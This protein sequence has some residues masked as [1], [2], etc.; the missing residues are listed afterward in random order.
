ME[1]VAALAILGIVVAIAAPFV[2]EIVRNNRLNSTVKTVVNYLEHARSHTLIDKANIIVCAHN[3]QNPDEC[4]D[5]E[6]W[7]AGF[8]LIKAQLKLVYRMHKPYEPSHPGFAPTKPTKPNIEAEAYANNTFKPIPM[9]QGHRFY[10]IYHMDNSNNGYLRSMADCVVPKIDQALREQKITKLNDLTHA[11]AGGLPLAKTSG[12]VD[13]SG[14]GNEEVRLPRSGT[15]DDKS[16]IQTMRIIDDIYT[17]FSADMFKQLGL[18][19]NK[20]D[21][22]KAIYK[23]RAQLDAALKK[24]FSSYIKDKNKLKANKVIYDD[25]MNKCSHRDS[26]QVARDADNFYRYLEMDWYRRPSEYKHLTH[27]EYR[28]PSE[29]KKS[30]TFYPSIYEYKRLYFNRAIDRYVARYY[31]DKNGN[32]SV[33]D[34]NNV[35]RELR[36]YGAKKGEEIDDY[37]STLNVDEFQEYGELKKH[38]YKQTH[39]A[40]QYEKDLA[41]YEIDKAN[42]EL[43]LVRY[44]EDYKQYL[45]RLKEYNNRKEPGLYFENPKAVLVINKLPSDVNVTLN[46][47]QKRIIY[48]PNMNIIEYNPY[49]WMMDQF[50]PMYNVNFVEINISDKRDKQ[51]SKNICI[52]NSGKIK[53]INGTEKCE[54]F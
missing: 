31:K 3:P 51:F 15:I 36:K 49:Y 2:Y 46:K 30:H 53:V 39:S 45:E 24:A 5:S 12:C 7:S 13:F 26:W 17:R 54:E 27:T 33:T 10:I 21:S 28:K 44:E 52:N 18:P 37:A 20:K 47:I 25:F 40:V 34:V 8:S 42:Y 41:K 48:D 50:Y 19:A 22:H 1:I 23:D 9:P 11:T 16:A 29:Q 35:A 43:A 14:C 38:I 4:L 32:Y 6:D